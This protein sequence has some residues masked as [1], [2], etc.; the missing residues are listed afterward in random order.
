MG[1]IDGLSPE[2]EIQ[3]IY[4]AYFGRAGDSGGV[5][6]WEGTFAGLTAGG[7]STDVALTAIANAFAPQTET[8]T[9][10]PQIPS[11]LNFQTAFPNGVSAASVPTSAL[12]AVTSFVN[13]AYL[14]MFNHPLPTG[15]TYWVDQILGINPTTG[16]A[17]APIPVGEALLLIANGA[18]GADEATVLNKINVGQSFTDQTSAAG[19]GFG[20]QTPG[21]AYLTEAHNVVVATTSD[22]ASVTAQEAAITAFIAGTNVPTFTLT[23]NEDIFSTA[24]AGVMFNAAPV[25]TPDSGFANNTL[26]AGDVLT[27]TAG[28]GT[29]NFTSTGAGVANPPFATNVSMSGIATL[30]FSATGG[31]D[32]G[33]QGNVTGL[34]AVNDTGSTAALTLGG[35]GQGLNTA[36]VNV[37][38]SGFSSPGG[39]HPLIFSGTIAQSVGNAAAGINVSLTGAV[40]ASTP[41][42]AAVLNIQN[43]G[44]PGTAAAPNLSYGGWNLTV[45]SN[46]FL[47][48]EQGGVGG[49][50]GLKLNGAGNMFLGSD[51]AGN[52]QDLTNID[53]SATS[54][55]VVI[56]GA[57]SGVADNAFGTAADPTWL[58]GSDA[59][60]LNEGVG[61]AFD[62]TAFLLGTG[63]NVL[64]VS[65]ATPV[66]LAALTTTPSAT[67]AADNAIIVS[68]AAAI[69]TVL[70][71]FAGIHG[72]AELGVVGAAGQIDMA[73]LPP[74]VNDIIYQ[75]ASSGDVTIIH[76]TA[77]LEVD[78]AQNG[79]GNAL[80]VTGSAALTVDIGNDA[81]SAP[82]AVG[83]LSATGDT[84]LTINAN[85]GGTVTDDL[86]S[87][88]WQP[89]AA[90]G[91]LTIQGDAGNLD[92]VGGI[93]ENDATPAAIIGSS[94][95]SNSQGLL[96]TEGNV[97]FTTTGGG[98]HITGSAS[99]SATGDFIGGGPGGD[100]FT[101]QSTTAPETVFTGGGGDTVDLAA[102]HTGV[103]VIDIYS[104]FSGAPVPGTDATSLSSVVGPTITDAADGAQA[105]WWGALP[106]D[107]PPALQFGKIPVNTALGPDTTT[108]NHFVPGSS[109][110]PQD[111][112]SF[113]VSAWGTTAGVDFGVTHGDLTTLGAGDVGNAS[114]Q[115]LT[116][117]APLATLSAAANI[118]YDPVASLTTLLSSLKGASAGFTFGGGAA[119][120]AGE[121]AH[122]I[123][124]YGGG[125]G[126]GDLQFADV[127]FTGVG[128]TTNAAGVNVTIS[129]MVD[130]TGILESQIVHGALAG[131]AFGVHWV[132]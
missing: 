51:G 111:H 29:L 8:T 11:I 48:L 127:D 46:A 88:V 23:P 71:T 7:A 64:D 53:A 47:Q 57:S 122:M 130:L 54:G 79:L 81:V 28:D 73:L 119:L 83:A 20:T 59:G 100:T 94:N 121:S 43:D 115:D 5:N 37:N 9:E 113:S 126:L 116:G 82:G 13:G 19:L 49:A 129:N 12:N 98:A 91:T 41:G 32:G 125:A 38:I 106:T 55:A 21:N 124:A 69:T 105:G 123:F 30:N 128:A 76:Q 50:T 103:N 16:A 26:N 117:L 3:A 120:A 1:A 110:T 68:D 89:P 31:A 99:P 10:F 132:A 92:I 70:A 44:N 63:R 56:T 22:P 118:F 104:G 65:A 93:V 114:V 96:M 72:F 40:G 90:G 36:L 86:A 131:N 18:T 84:A 35:I 102:G 45:N 17:Q 95:A 112:I 101:L 61:G 109:T 60:L 74:D 52:W 67:V 107:A 24:A 77:A 58:L 62:L 27:D 97:F 25:V 15:D 33:F 14:N 42:G 34:T 2:Q 66:Q 4:V 75:T 80:S 108:I 85:G 6:F 78:T 87:I 39:V